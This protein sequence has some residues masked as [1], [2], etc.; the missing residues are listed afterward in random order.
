MGDTQQVVVLAAYQA[1]ESAET[2]FDQLVQLVR[3]K[4][5][6]SEGVILVE[7]DAEGRVTVDQT[8]DHLGRKGMGFGGGVGI[9]VG[10]AAPPLLAATVVGA[11]GG[12]LLGKLASKKVESGLES[13][14]GEKLKPGTAAIV[15]IIDERGPAGRRA[16]AR[17][18]RRPSRCAPIRRHQ[19]LQGRARRGDGQVH[20]DRTVLPIPDRAFGGSAGHTIDESAA[21]WSFIP[22]PSGTRGRPERA[23]RPHRRRRLRR[24]RHVRRRDQHAEPDPRAADGRHLQP[25][26]RHGGLLADAGRA[27]HRPQPPPRRHG[28]HRRAPGAVPRLHGHP[29]AQL[30]R[31]A[32]H[33]AGE[34]LHHRGLRQV[35]HDARPRDGRR[36][37][38]RPLAHGLGLRPLVGLPDRRRRPV[39]PDHHPGQLHPRRPRGRGRQALLLPRRHHRQGGRVAARRPR[40]G[41]RTSRGSCTT[42]PACTHAPHHVA[43]EWADKYKGQFDDGWDDYREQTLERQKK[44]GHRARRTPS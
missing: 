6:K 2:D 8:G 27:A 13:G 7:K 9:A 12:A 42:P 14:M 28:R 1:L 31:P 11:A 3:E 33:P 20:P 5:V 24:P 41:R 43:K 38:V 21:D 10:L 16:G 44:L 37:A 18:A 40:A 25:V 19:G 4:K 15:A 34:R 36:R 39:R 30:H 23:H 22:G 35:A 29:A 17:R 26:P 32:A